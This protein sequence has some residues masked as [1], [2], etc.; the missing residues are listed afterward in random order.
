MSLS[1]LFQGPAEVA[2]PRGKGLRLPQDRQS[3]AVEMIHLADR[4]NPGQGPGLLLGPIMSHRY[5][6]I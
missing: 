2:I 4:V 3:E 1:H 6:V 5:R